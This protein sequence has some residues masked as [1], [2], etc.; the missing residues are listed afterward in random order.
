MA[1]IM[2]Q[3]EM[4]DQLAQKLILFINQNEGKLS[5][6]KRDKE[7]STLTD[8]EVRAIEFIVLDAFE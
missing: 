4:P 8:E 7:F 1:R 3:I 5:K 2:E 6:K